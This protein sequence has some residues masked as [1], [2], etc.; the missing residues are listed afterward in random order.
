MGS[1]P[2]GAMAIVTLPDG[3][4]RQ[5][6]ELLYQLLAGGLREL[7]AAGATLWGGH[8]TQGPELTIGY[9]VAGKLGDKPPFTKGNLRPGDQ[10]IL[11]KPLGTATLLVAHALCLCPA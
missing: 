5:Q 7:T 9:S 1:R 3:P 10:L 2:L 8:T 11:T 6:T 4:P